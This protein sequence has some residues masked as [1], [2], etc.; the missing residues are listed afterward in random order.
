MK[1]PDGTLKLKKEYSPYTHGVCS[2]SGTTLADSIAALQLT[3]GIY[4]CTLEAT[5]K[6]CLPGFEEQRITKS[7]SSILSVGTGGECVSYN[8]GLGKDAPAGECFLGEFTVPEAAPSR[9]GH[10]FECWNT[11]PDGSGQSFA[12]GETVSYP[13]SLTLYPVWSA[14]E[15]GWEVNAEAACDG[16]FSLDG[17]VKN[18]KGITSLR[19]LLSGGEGVSIDR[20]AEL[21]ANEAELD[22]LFTEEQISLEPG[23]YTVELLGS[24]GGHAEESIFKTVLTVESSEPVVTEAPLLTPSPTEEPG[25]KTPFFNLAA[26]PIAVWFILGAAVVV[27]LIAAI[28]TI[29]K[30][31]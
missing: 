26:V 4:T 19:M 1:L 27:G 11:S 29:I 28:I 3:E 7:N 10:V 31:G 13:S 17:T 25:E 24:A 16:Y 21:C 9:P 22:G 12:K 20:I 23:E 18:T 30:R 5:V 8:C 2:L 15:G 14:S 6:A